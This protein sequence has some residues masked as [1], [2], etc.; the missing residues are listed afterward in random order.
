MMPTG[1][2]PRVPLDQRLWSRVE[3]EALWDC[4]VWQG[5]KR[6]GYGVI[7]DKGRLRMT[8]RVAYELSVGP[9]PDGLTLDHLCRNRACVN[10]AHLEPVT[11]GE[12]IRR[13]QPYRAAIERCVNGHSY[14]PENTYANARGWRRCRE[15]MRAQQ[16]R[17]HATR[18]K[19]AA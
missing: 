15:C 9:I 13:G 19:A 7:G 6:W 14:T 16:E 17:W 8:H 1:F 4:W 3:R 10:P 12:N 2:Y 5:A 11:I 18:K